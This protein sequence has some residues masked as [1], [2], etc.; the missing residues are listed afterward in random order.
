MPR[1]IKAILNIAEEVLG[2]SI[3]TDALEYYALQIE[4]LGIQPAF[5][6]LEEFGIPYQLARKLDYEYKKHFSDRVPEIDD[7]ISFVKEIYSD[8]N[9]ADLPAFEYSLLDSFKRTV[10]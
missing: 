4:N 8:V 6:A 9:D 1:A 5:F 7:A 2:D 3:A 10:R